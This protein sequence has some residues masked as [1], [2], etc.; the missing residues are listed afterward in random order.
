M[1]LVF[2]SFWI[3]VKFLSRRACRAGFKFKNAQ[4]ERG[5]RN[6]I[7]PQASFFLLSRALTT[8]FRLPL[9]RPAEERRGRQARCG[10]SVSKRRSGG[11][12]LSWNRGRIRGGEGGGGGG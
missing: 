4:T 3:D 12:K 6:P 8:L 2:R 1:K 7:R 10:G 9:N 5:G 11:A